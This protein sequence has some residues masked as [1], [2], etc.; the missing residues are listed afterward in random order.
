MDRAG[1]G[2]MFPRPEALT[3]DP[4]GCS[5]ELDMTAS[6]GWFCVHLCSLL[7]VMV[8]AFYC[9]SCVICDFLGTYSVVTVSC[10]CV[11]SCS[12]ITVSCVCV[13]S[14][15]GISQ[16]CVCLVIQV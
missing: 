4:H 8:M 12:V 16:L 14:Y 7:V 9:V 6:D 13:L 2:H 15:S 10:V 11:L 5:M 1:L 3:S